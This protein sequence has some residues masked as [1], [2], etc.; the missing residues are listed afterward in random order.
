[1]FK[2]NDT[3][4]LLRFRVASQHFDILF[5]RLN[6][7]EILNGLAASNIV[8]TFG[9]KAQLAEMTKTYRIYQTGF[10]VIAIRY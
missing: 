1:M 7:P 2:L 3:Y 10:L 5:H 8:E 9:K 4:S 6:F